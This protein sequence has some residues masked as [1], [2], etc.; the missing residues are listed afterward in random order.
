MLKKAVLLGYF[1]FN[2]ILTTQKV[3]ELFKFEANIRCLLGER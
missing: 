1:N 2:L 3:P